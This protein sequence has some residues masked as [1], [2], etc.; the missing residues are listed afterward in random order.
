MQ[1]AKNLQT[2]LTLVEEK[3]TSLEQAIAGLPKRTPQY[4]RFSLERT[5]DYLQ[6]QA[7]FLRDLIQEAA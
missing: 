2:E 3:L 1:N 7:R 5:R 4:Q 6:N